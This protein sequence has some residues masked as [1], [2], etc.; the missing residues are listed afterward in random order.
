[1]LE[2]EIR[3]MAYTPRWSIVRTQRQQYLAEHT[4]FV[5]MYANDIAVYLNL[6][7]HEVGALLQ[8]CLWH[9]V[10]EIF[11]GD[12]PG[13]CKRAGMGDHRKLWDGKLRY[14]LNKVFSKLDRRDGSHNHCSP[15]RVALI[16]AILKLAD[17]IDECCEMG[18]EIQMGNATVKRIF[19]DSLTRVKAAVNE[20]IK[21][22]RPWTNDPV[23]EGKFRGKC[24]GACLSARDGESQSTRIFET[25]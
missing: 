21:H 24:I 12:I 3:E 15:D 16:E 19:D 9:D 11:S 13:P 25:L 1:M 7:P 23:E 18:S 4:Y 22:H 5:C 8:M 10:E 20:V 2:R 6:A 14:W 17:M